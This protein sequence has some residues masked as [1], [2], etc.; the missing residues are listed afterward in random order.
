MTCSHCENENLSDYPVCATCATKLHFTNRDDCKCNQ[1]KA[2]AMAEVLPLVYKTPSE[3][4]LIERTN[5][6]YRFRLPVAP[7]PQF[8]SGLQQHVTGYLYGYKSAEQNYRSFPALRLELVEGMLRYWLSEQQANGQN[9]NGGKCC[10]VRV[11]E[12][13]VAS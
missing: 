8:L 9:R 1:C 13:E 3:E 6:G 7:C 12:S 4:V 10:T 11:V 5:R 2:K